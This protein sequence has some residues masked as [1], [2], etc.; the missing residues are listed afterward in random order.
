MIAAMNKSLYFF[1]FL[2]LPFSFVANAQ[3]KIACILG[4]T[5]SV[6]LTNARGTIQWQNSSD[7]ISWANI[8]DQNSSVLN[9]FPYSGNQWV[10]AIL[11][12]N[13]CPEFIDEPVEIFALDTTL[14]GIDVDIV[15]LDTVLIQFQAD[16]AQQVNGIYQFSSQTND[17]SLKP[18]DII[19]GTD[20]EGYLRF[21]DSYVLQ[22]GQ[23][24]VY[25]H[26]ATLDDLFGD[27]GFS[28]DISADSLETRS[29]GFNY[30]FDQTV[31]YQQGP[32]TLSLTSGN[33]GMTGDWSGG[34]EY[35]LFSGLQSFYFGTNNTNLSAN[36]TFNLTA[37]QEVEL[38]NGSKS[39]AKF[40][41]PIR[42]LVGGIPVIITL[43]AELIGSWNLSL[44]AEAQ[45][46]A[47]LNSNLSLTTGLSYANGQWNNTFNVN[48]TSSIQFTSPEGQVQ[49]VLKLALIPQL[50]MKI[51][52]LVV[53]YINPSAHLDIY[54][55]IA[56][57]ELNWDIKAEGYGKLEYG[58]EDIVIFGETIAT[59]NPNLFESTHTELYKTP[60]V[61][62]Q[63][64]GNGQSGQINTTLANSIIVRVNDSF[65]FAQRNVPVSV[66]VTSGNGTVSQTELLSNENGL[67]S[68]EW[69]LGNDPMQEQELNFVIKDGSDQQI[70]GSPL[71][72]YA[73]FG[74][75]S[76]LNLLT[77]MS[78]KTWL[79]AP[80]FCCDSITTVPPSILT[81]FSNGSVNVF[82]EAYSCGQVNGIPCFETGDVGNENFS[83]SF[84]SNCDSLNIENS[85]GQEDV[86]L[87][88]ISDT[89]LILNGSL[90]IAQ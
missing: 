42:V 21:V 63:I 77:N 44:S 86:Y 40:S 59:F 50:K 54:G 88:S 67:V 37:T 45:M 18:G 10:R 82:S 3:T 48:P 32:V 64:S 85:T 51:Y 76:I 22:N 2:S 14:P 38:I 31:L 53:P 27:A 56:S 24:S 23:L 61:L 28:F 46:N 72:I 30:D 71:V 7:S 80:R 16:S 57:P 15:V 26:Q 12:E 79:S 83:W 13:N 65:G 66:E 8:T 89:E 34:M 43:S 84:T 49:A 78:Q 75:D 87:M 1:L 58:L 90:F 62:E 60:Y 52:G 4:D 33:I 47:S 68:I 35:S 81:F 9:Y 25:T 36:F 55:T 6:E 5:L 29:S 11:N 74:C 69:T 17:P 19:I 73:D 70:S 41:K 39:L 20:G